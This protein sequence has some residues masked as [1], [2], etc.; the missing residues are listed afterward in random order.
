[1][2]LTGVAVSQLALRRLDTSVLQILSL[3]NTNPGN[4]K[5]LRANSI[6]K[7]SYI[8]DFLKP[9]NEFS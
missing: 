4:F 8:L 5:G 3:R 6:S 9:G 7:I 1:M 2:R